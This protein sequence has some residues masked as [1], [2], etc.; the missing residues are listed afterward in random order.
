MVGAQFWWLNLQ[1]KP[2]ATIEQSG[3]HRA[4]RAHARRPIVGPTGVV[5]AGPATG[6]DGLCRGAFPQTY[7]GGNSGERVERKRP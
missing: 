7:G 2:D 1:A 3:G 4:V 6:V 5:P